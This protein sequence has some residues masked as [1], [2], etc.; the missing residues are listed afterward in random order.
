MQVTTA[1]ESTPLHFSDSV[2]EEEFN[3]FMI[4]PQRRKPTNSNYD[5]SQDV[6]IN[7]EA[8]DQFIPRCKNAN[9]TTN[10]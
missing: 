1:T 8:H 7:H 9:S 6:N 2:V 10:M 3:T 4:T 5:K